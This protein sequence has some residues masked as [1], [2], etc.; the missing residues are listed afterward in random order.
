MRPIIGAQS[1]RLALGLLAAGCALVLAGCSLLS[2]AYPRLPDLATRWLDGQLPLTGPQTDALQRDLGTVLTWHRREHLPAT[3]QLLE[4]WAGLLAQPELKAEQLCTEWATVRRLA[5]EVTRQTLPALARL[6]QSLEPEQLVALQ[7]A[8]QQSN[9]EFRRA[10]KPSR[11]WLPWM[12]AAQASTPQANSATATATPPG[13]P[14][15]L[16]RL[17]DRY[18]Q[19]YGPLNEAQTQRLG[20]LLMTSRYDPERTLAER[21]RQQADLR[22]VLA[23]VRSTAPGSSASSPGSNAAPA[24]TAPSGA[25]PDTPAAKAAQQALADWLQRMWASPTPGYSTYSQTLLRETCEQWAQ[26]HQLASTAQRQHASQRLRGYGAEL[27]A[28]SAP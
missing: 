24:S 10:L 28:L 20:L 13:H 26:V 25:L 18:S 2:L 14:Q 3:A 11:S 7:A 22:S 8:Q 9:D 27:L 15:R 4:R 23:L 16:K 12:G 17:G 6:A 5:D 19:L 1:R 21:Q